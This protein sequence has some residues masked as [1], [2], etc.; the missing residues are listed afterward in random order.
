MAEPP[1]RP[2]RL[3]P[4]L[5]LFDW[6]RPAKAAPRGVDLAKRAGEVR[7]LVLAKYP[8]NSIDPDDIVQETLLTIHRRNSLPSAYDPSKSG[9]AHYVHIVAANVLGH[10]SKAPRYRLEAG[11][12][13]TD[14]V[15]VPD[16][17]SPLDTIELGEDLDVDLDA[18][19]QL[20]EL[21]PRR[22]RQLWEIA[23]EQRK[24]EQASLAAEPV[25]AVQSRRTVSGYSRRAQRQAALPCLR[26]A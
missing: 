2:R 16:H 19:R 21:V 9:F 10:M 15:E 26:A 3:S 18:S 25:S 6:I 5:D 8:G 13:D 24:K 12:E 22:P 11:E 17:R 14:A 23:L 4:Q 20:G 1:A 7:R